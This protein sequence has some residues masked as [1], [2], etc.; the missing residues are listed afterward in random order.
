MTIPLRLINAWALTALCFAAL[1]MPANADPARWSIA[2]EGGVL[3]KIAP[4]DVHQDFIEMDGEQVAVVVR[5]GINSRG[6]FT[7][8]HDVI[9]PMLRFRPN[10]TDDHLRMSFGEDASSD[11]DTRF[12]PALIPA[13]YVLVD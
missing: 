2:Q 3:W 10:L 7:V 8:N 11:Q 1:S 13:I 9:W 12:R 5:Y 6:V 4:A